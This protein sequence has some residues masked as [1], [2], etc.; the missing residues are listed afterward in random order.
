[1]RCDECA[2]HLQLGQSL[3]AF[4]LQLFLVLHRA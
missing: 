1:L 4:H 3:L 2:T